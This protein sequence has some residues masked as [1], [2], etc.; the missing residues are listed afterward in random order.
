MATAPR[1]T[2]IIKYNLKDRGRK[3][4]KDR[5]DIDI[6][7][8]VAMLNSAETQDKV[9]N[10]D[11]KGY[12]GHQVRQRFGLFPPETA[13]LDGKLITIEPAFKTIYLKA[14]ADGT[15]EHQQEFFDNTIGN[16]VRQQYKANAGAFSSHIRFQKPNGTGLKKPVFISGFDFV[17]NANY[18][19]NKGDGE[20]YDSLVDDELYDAFDDVMGKDLSAIPAE[21]ALVAQVLEQNI[22]DQYDS[23][24]T[25][26]SII[27]FASGAIDQVDKLAE[28]NADLSAANQQMAK[29]LQKREK[30]QQQYQEDVFDSLLCPATPFEQALEQANQFSAKKLKAIRD[31][32]G[33]QNKK[34]EKGLDR[35]LGG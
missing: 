30:A 4:G 16:F 17:K 21:K 35:L 14:Y 3:D 25:A 20:L 23:A 1:K 13:I 19:T 26:M 24:A 9:K 32:A 18:A 33:S 11:L 8:T 29:R 31:T 10:G 7:A 28:Q 22:I 6:A 34:L 15:V 12:Y 2:G 27:S 5:S